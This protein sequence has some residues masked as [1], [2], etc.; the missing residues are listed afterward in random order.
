MVKV[1]IILPVY[2]VE[3]YLNECLDSIVNQTFSDMEII[4]INDGS[5]DNSLAILN[6]YASRDGRIKIISQEN[7]GM[8]LLE[9][10]E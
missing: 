4:C 1:S 2:N 8:G 3:K 9:M 7:A 10:L 5:T 6:S